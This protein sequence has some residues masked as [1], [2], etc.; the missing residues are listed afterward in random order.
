M[1]N[2]VLTLVLLLK[3]ILVGKGLLDNAFTEVFLKQKPFM[4]LHINIYDFF[5]NFML[6][7]QEE[8][9]GNHRL[10]GYTYFHSDWIQVMK[11]WFSD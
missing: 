1:Q 8:R 9:Q 3:A 7:G 6:T 10:K 5:S 4:T 2:N 11:L